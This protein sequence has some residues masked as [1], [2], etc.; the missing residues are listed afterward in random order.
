MKKYISIDNGL[1]MLCIS[2]FLFMMFMCSQL[3]FAGYKENESSKQYYVINEEEI[4]AGQIN[5]VSKILREKNI[6]AYI[7]G[8]Y[9]RD[10]ELFDRNEVRLWLYPQEQTVSKG[11]PMIE[12]SVQDLEW[13]ALPEDER[14][15]IAEEGN[16]RETEFEKLYLVFLGEQEPV[17]ACIRSITS[18]MDIS[19]SDEQNPERGNYLQSFQDKMMLYSVVVLLIFGIVCMFSF[20]ELW[21]YSRRREWMICRVYGFGQGDIAKGILKEL[22]AVY[23]G[24]VGCGIILALVYHLGYHYIYMMTGKWMLLMAAEITIAYLLF[25]GYIIVRGYKMMNKN[26]GRKMIL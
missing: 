14:L 3:L 16:K 23:A 17:E 13:K 11:K 2:L 10:G 5:Q 12:D 25:S 9:V 21:I 7:G 19:R 8:I 6:N 15:L 24:A 4:N 20:A 22:Q 1:L 18:Y 26:N